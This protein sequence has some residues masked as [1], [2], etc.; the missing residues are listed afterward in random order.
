MAAGTLLRGNQSIRSRSLL[1]L[2]EAEV[3]ERLAHSRYLTTV[4][5]VHCFGEPS[6]A[7]VTVLRVRECA[8]WQISPRTRESAGV[9]VPFADHTCS[10]VRAMLLLLCDS[11][12]NARASRRCCAGRSSVPCGAYH[13]YLS[14][15]SDHFSCSS[16][17]HTFRFELRER[18]LSSAP[19]FFETRGYPVPKNREKSKNQNVLQ[20]RLKGMIDK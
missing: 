3:I 14:C 15:S 2:Q 5:L 20:K 16:C 18:H 19:T 6:V 13:S 4:T 1:H 11:R 17:F 12:D 7:S 9:H 8:S 10:H